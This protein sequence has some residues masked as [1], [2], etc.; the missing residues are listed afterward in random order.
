MKN[1][2]DKLELKHIAPYL[3]YELNAYGS[4]DIWKILFCSNHKIAMSNGRHT[5][6]RDIDD[7]NTE[8]DLILRP[9]SDLAKEI[10]VNGEKFIPIVELW[11]KYEAHEFRDNDIYTLKRPVK[12]AGFQT[13]KYNFGGADHTVTKIKHVVETNN[14]GDLVYDFRY[15]WELRRFASTDTTRR[16]N[17]AIAYQYD[18]FHK[19]F[20]WHFD[21]F[22][23]IK[24]GLAIDIN[25]I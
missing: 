4:S 22:G 23:L 18:L 19:L 1:T 21:V 25:T 24:S 13:N 10:E 14:M 8:Y 17:H 2:M 15:E 20:E 9:L 3:P 7:F 12:H 6:T 16:I 5:L 11:E